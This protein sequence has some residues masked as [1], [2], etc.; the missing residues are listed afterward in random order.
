M[1]AAGRQARP[2]HAR[3]EM[4]QDFQDIDELAKVAMGGRGWPGGLVAWWP[5]T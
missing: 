3:K 1:M 2:Q 4:E 5:A